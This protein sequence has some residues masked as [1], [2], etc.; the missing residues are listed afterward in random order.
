MTETVIATEMT[1]IETVIG[2]TVVVTVT[3]I[4][5]GVRLDGVIHRSEEEVHQEEKEHLRDG[6]VV[7]GDVQD[8]RLSGQG[9]LE[10]RRL[11][12][13]EDIVLVVVV[14]V[15]ILIKGDM[16]VCVCVHS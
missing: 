7:R 9:H 6:V 5:I 2:V 11:D 8:H 15:L 4:G 13:G 3:G 16:C 10:S 12:L 1:G 14:A